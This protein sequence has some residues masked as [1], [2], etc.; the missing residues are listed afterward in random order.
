[1]NSIIKV[2]PRFVRFGIFSLIE[3]QVNEVDAE[4]VERIKEI[5]LSRVAAILRL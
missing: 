4:D 2:I 5:I 1:M 3:E